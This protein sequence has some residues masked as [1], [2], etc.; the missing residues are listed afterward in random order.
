MNKKNT[1]FT[2]ENPDCDEETCQ[3]CCPHDDIDHGICPQCE[4]DMNGDLVDAAHAS[5]EGDR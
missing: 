2:C 5:L 4:L 1:T 3:S